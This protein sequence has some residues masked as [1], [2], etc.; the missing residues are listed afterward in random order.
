MLVRYLVYLHLIYSTGMYI[1][2]FYIHDCSLYYSLILDL[3]STD[4]ERRLSF[5]FALVWKVIV[6]FYKPSIIVTVLVVRGAIAV[7]GLIY[8]PSGRPKG[9]IYTVNES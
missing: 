4:S 3:L 6:H 7:T 1:L 5:L 9:Q 8:Y 2:L